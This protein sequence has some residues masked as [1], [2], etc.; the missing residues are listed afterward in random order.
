MK[1]KRAEPRVNLGCL[2][3]SLAASFAPEWRDYEIRVILGSLNIDGGSR[4]EEWEKGRAECEHKRLYR[5][6]YIY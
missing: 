5:D 4:A 3:V 2:H 6:E 1:Q